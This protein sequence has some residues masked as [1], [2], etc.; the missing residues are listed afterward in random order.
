[1]A[2]LSQQRS[3]SINLSPAQ[4]RPRGVELSPSGEARRLHSRFRGKTPSAQ[5]GAATIVQKDFDNDE[6]KHELWRV[7][8]AAK[9]QPKPPRISLKSEPG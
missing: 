4:L 6:R 7:D 3:C 1:M 2:D 5:N 8:R 9:P